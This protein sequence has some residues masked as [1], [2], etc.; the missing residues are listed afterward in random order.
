MCINR[1]NIKKSWTE[2][3]YLAYLLPLMFNCKWEKLFE[4]KIAVNI[5]AIKYENNKRTLLCLLRSGA[6]KT[7]GEER[8]SERTGSMQNSN[9]GYKS[10]TLI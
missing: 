10:P 8:V 9:P 2:L 6:I 7:E 5:N 1:G 3:V 4:Y